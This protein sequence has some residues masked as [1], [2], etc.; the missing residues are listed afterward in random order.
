MDT[1]HAVILGLLIS[2][3]FFEFIRVWEETKKKG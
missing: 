1:T 3:V 2:L